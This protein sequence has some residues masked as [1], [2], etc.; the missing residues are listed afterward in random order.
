MGRVGAWRL[1]L[2]CS[3]LGSVGLVEPY[4]QSDRNDE[5]GIE[6]V[7]LGDDVEAL[8]LDPDYQAGQERW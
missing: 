8:N 1:D 3:V 4:R 6:F 5:G 2:R 7:G